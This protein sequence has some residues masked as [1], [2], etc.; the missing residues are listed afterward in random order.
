MTKITLVT[1][2][3]RGLGRNT[4]LSI[5]RQG[6]DVVLTYQSRGEDAQA[7]VVEIEA[8]GRKAVAF[9]LDAGDVAA[10]ANQAPPADDQTL[11]AMRCL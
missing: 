8:M 1:G 10:F 4:A 7:V 6:G 3:S 2:A 9:Q 5:A 11:V